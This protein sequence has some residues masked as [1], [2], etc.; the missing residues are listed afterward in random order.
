MKKI[1]KMANY[2]T[3]KMANKCKILKITFNI[4]N[5]NTPTKKTRMRRIG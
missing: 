2:A 5:L 1:H 4:N 3:H